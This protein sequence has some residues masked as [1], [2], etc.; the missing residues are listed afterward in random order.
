MLCFREMRLF[1]LLGVFLL[2]GVLARWWFWLG[3]GKA[4]LLWAGA[5][6]V[7]A[8]DPAA[9]SGG[10]ADPNM[11]GD[12]G[13]GA[14]G[15]ANVPAED[16]LLAYGTALAAAESAYAAPSAPASSPPST[17]PGPASPDSPP[18]PATK[19]AAPASPSVVATGVA[20][21]VLLD[22][23]SA[24]PEELMQ[25]PGIGPVLAEAILAERAR[26]GR[27]T[28]VSDLLSVKGIGQARLE[29]IAPYVYIANP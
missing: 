10:Q 13:A 26:R 20:Q 12:A 9:G 28:A 17:M 2:L 18:A 15:D 23:N 11:A 5:E 19:N 25:L 6:P 14:G 21:P 24:G 16:H 3:P 22:L 8:A 27:F 1:A 29:R 7:E 4:E